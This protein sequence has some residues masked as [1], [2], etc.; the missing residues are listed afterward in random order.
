MSV[1]STINQIPILELI[2]ANKL[3]EPHIKGKVGNSGTK[4]KCIFHSDNT[5]S[6]NIYPDDRQ[7][8]CFGCGKSHTSYDVLKYLDYTINEMVELAIQEYGVEPDDDSSSEDSS[9]VLNKEIADWVSNN[10]GLNRLDRKTCRSAE[11]HLKRMN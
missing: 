4:I 1:F 7:S 8:Y 9:F 5:P 11:K 2:K 3:D 6:W 10:R